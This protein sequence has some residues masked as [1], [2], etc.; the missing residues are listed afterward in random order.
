MGQS[1]A[2]PILSMTPREM[3]EGGQIQEALRALQDSVRRRPLATEDRILLFEVLALEGLWDRALTQL[4]VLVTM[5]P[6]AMAF[7][8]V[9]EPLVRAE[10]QRGQIERGEAAPLVFGE[11]QQWMAQAL[12]GNELLVKK[13]IGA[14]SNALRSATMASPEIGGILNGAKCKWV[15]DADLRFGPFLEAVI[16]GRFFWIPFFRIL[17][18]KTEAPKHLRDLLWLRAG[19]TWTNGGEAEGFILARYPGTE[20]AE[21][22]LLKLNRKTEWRSLEGGMQLGFGQRLIASDNC[23]Y[24]ILEVRELTLEGPGG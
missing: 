19:F 21:D 13:E 20:K 12:H 18:V 8:R 7:G 9:H 5:E 16:E 2:A 10:I 24:P 17:T 11:P 22:N 1:N 23:D 15:G 6:N 4:E 14:A 3:L